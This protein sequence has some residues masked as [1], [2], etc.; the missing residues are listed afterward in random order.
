MIFTTLRR[1]ATSGFLNFWRNSFVSIA[2]IFVMS[3]TLFVIASL[4]MTSALLNSTLN[5][6]RDR[7]DITVFFVNEADPEEVDAVVRAVKELPEVSAVTFTSSE[8]NLERFRNRFANEELTLQALDELGYNPLQASLNIKAKEPSQYEGIAEF[9]VN[10][11]SV[12]TGDSSVIARV[13]YFQNKEVIER[14]TEI[15]NATERGGLILTI[16]FIV[17]SMMITFNTIRLAIYNS[18]DAIQIMRLVGASN[19]FARGPYIVEGGMYGLIAGVLVLAL[20][21]PL[22]FWL[23]PTTENFFGDINIFEY[24]LQ[25]FPLFFLVILGSG[26][27]LGAISSFIAARRYLKV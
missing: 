23:G 5:Q 18:R 4:M 10:Q 17:A 19:F 25:Q 13:N 21:F 16:L 8:E 14:L 3:M 15:L 27:V 22:T 26:L 24:Y 7:V 9:L 2:A 1:I 12:D 11:G 20:L 6:I